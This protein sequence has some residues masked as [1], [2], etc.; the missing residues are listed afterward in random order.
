MADKYDIINSLIS[1]LHNLADYRGIDK[2]ITIVNMYQN[3]KALE[4]IMHDEDA[5]R[6]KGDEDAD[7][8]A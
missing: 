5:A 8:K 4:G 1:Q 3:L 2:S 6:E 7:N